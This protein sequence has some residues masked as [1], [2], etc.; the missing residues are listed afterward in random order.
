[1][2]MVVV[3]VMVVVIVIMVVVVVAEGVELKICLLC[4]PLREKPPLDLAALAEMESPIH[5]LDLGAARRRRWVAC[6]DAG[7]GVDDGEGRLGGGD[8]GGD[9]G[10]R[11]SG[12]D[13]DVHGCWGATATSGN[14]E[15]DW[16]WEG[17][18]G[19]LEGAEQ[20]KIDIIPS[21]K[22]GFAIISSYNWDSPKYHFQL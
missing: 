2:A 8:G 17:G 14:E 13:D 16:G 22:R 12:D 1:M 11:S 20:E 3:V 18:G 9:R 5:I 21:S 6:K 7:D 19:R 4:E 15:L 10:I